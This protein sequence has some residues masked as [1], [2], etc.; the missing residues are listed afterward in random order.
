MKEYNY[1]ASW[2]VSL[3]GGTGTFLLKW[4]FIG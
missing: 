1:R 2:R 4:K 3:G